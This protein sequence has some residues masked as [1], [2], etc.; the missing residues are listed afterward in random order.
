MVQATG[1]QRMAQCT[2][3]VL[4]A[5]QRFKVP[6]TVFASEDLIGHVRDF[7][8]DSVRCGQD[9]TLAIQATNLQ[10]PDNKKAARGS[11]FKN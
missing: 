3:D 8:V 10:L 2:Y 1:I 11:F 5:D 9:C 4:L 6:G 7:T